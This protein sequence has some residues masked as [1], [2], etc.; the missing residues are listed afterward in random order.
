MFTIVDG[1][2]EDVE[3]RVRIN[4]WDDVEVTSRLDGVDVDRIVLDSYTNDLWE[5]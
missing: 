3:H 4:S 1:V 5:D 2:Y